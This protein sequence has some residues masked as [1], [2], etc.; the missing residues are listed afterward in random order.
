VSW[1]KKNSIRQAIKKLKE[2]RAK[3]EQRLQGVE[4]LVEAWQKADDEHRGP[5]R[6]QKRLLCYVREGTALPFH[7]RVWQVGRDLY[8][9]PPCF[10]CSAFWVPNTHLLPYTLAGVSQL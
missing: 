5:R 2:R 1:Q 7:L 10:F 6:M 4:L 8:A 3:A 9:A